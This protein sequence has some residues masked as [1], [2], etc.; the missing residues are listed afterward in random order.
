MPCNTG[1]KHGIWH[2]I[3]LKL[4]I[5]L[6]LGNIENHCHLGLTF[7]SN[8]KWSSHIQVIRKIVSQRLGILQSLKFA[9]SRKSL[10]HIYLT[11]ILPIL[12]YGDIIYD[13]CSAKDSKSLDVLHTRAA[14]IV[15]GAA[16][17]SNTQRLLDE[18]LGWEGLKSRRQRHK[19]C[20]FYRIVNQLD[21]PPYLSALLPAFIGSNGS[22][23]V[24]TIN[25]HL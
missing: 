20:L 9:L 22:Y 23:H 11:M 1:P 6:Y 3:L 4:F 14:R 2:L 24:C 16:A 8:M 7:S 12:D 10:E 18:E 19:L 17:S 5:C 15:S 13:N 21:V 25:R